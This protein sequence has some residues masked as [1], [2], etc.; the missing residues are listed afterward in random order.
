MIDA[1]GVMTSLERR[2]QQVRAQTESLVEGL[3]A[4]D[5]QV[6]SMPDAS[7][8]RWHLAHVTW[9]FETFVLEPHEPDFVPHHRAFRV[10]SNS[11]YNGVGEQHPRPQRGLVTRP[12]LAEVMAYR[13]A[14][15]ALRG[16]RGKCDF[17][18]GC[19]LPLHAFCDAPPEAP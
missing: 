1:A 10:L 11:Y 14:V 9:F 16:H 6:Q 7:P 2:Y 13:R 5:C 8:A 17:P 19:I 12:D 18:E 15:D 4:A 3:S